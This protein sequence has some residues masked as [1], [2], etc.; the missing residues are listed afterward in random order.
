MTRIICISGDAA[1]GKT[2]AARRVLERL[3]GWRIVSTG[4]RFREYC[5][6]RGLDPQQ[7]SH[8]GD[9]IH[10]D[11]DADMLRLLSEERNLIAEARLV[12]YLAREMP[13][14]LRV[15]CDCPLD[16][17]AERFRTREPG[18]SLEEAVARVS[19]RDEADT[20]NLRQL[21]G[22]DYHDPAYYHLVLDTSKLTPDEIAERILAA[23]ERLPHQ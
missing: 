6:E 8:L 1:S 22:I 9:Q 7:I 16:V 20:A 10:R 18:Y 5:A 23:A 21:Y 19:E 14:A 11:F 3:S 13:D 17:R 12:G 2:T 15:F 4:G